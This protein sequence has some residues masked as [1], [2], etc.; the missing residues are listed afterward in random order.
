MEISQLAKAFDS[1]GKQRGAQNIMQ[2]KWTIQNNRRG[3]CFH[4][5]L[6]FIL[7]AA[8]FFTVRSTE[9]LVWNDSPQTAE[10][11]YGFQ[12]GIPGPPAAVTP[13]CRDEGAFGLRWGAPDLMET[14][15]KRAFTCVEFGGY[16][17]LSSV[18]SFTGVAI[19]SE[20]YSPTE[21]KPYLGKIWMAGVAVLFGLLA[22]LLFVIAREYVQTNLAA[23]SILLLF[24]FSPPVVSGAW[25]LFSGGIQ[26]TVP[27]FICLGLWLYRKTSAAGRH[28]RLWGLGLALALL[29]GPW[30]REYIGIV[31]ALIIFLELQKHRRVTWILV[32]ALLGFLHAL[33]P[34]ALLH[35]FLPKLPLVPVFRLGSLA[36]Q[37]NAAAGGG[38]SL[39]SSIAQAKWEVGKVFLVLLPPS[40]FLASALILLFSLKREARFPVVL[41]GLAAP[42]LASLGKPWFW[43]ALIVAFCGLT[44]FQALH[45]RSEPDRG[46]PPAGDATARLHRVVFLNVWF[47]VSLLPFLKVFSAH[48]H[49]AYPLI[50]AAILIVASTERSWRDILERSSSAIWK[51][52]I[53]VPV[54]LICFLDQVLNA[55][56]SYVTVS[57]LNGGIRL[58]AN[59]MRANTPRGTIVIANA[60]HAEDIRFY[61]QN[62]ILPYWSVGVGV[63]PER[64]LEKPAEL[65]KFLRS[66][67]GSE[68]I[69]ML[70]MDQA[71]S[72][73]KGN[74]HAHKYITRN[75]VK[76]APLGS[77]YSMAGW[78]PFVDPV[79]NFLPRQMV[80][81]LGPPD[82]END[83]YFGRDRSRRPF[84]NEISVTYKAYVVLNPNVSPMAYYMPDSTFLYPRLLE[85]YRD[86]KLIG[87]R[88]NLL[89]VPDDLP[90]KESRL[91][92][93]ADNRIIVG[94]SVDELKA[95]I[96][97]L[98]PQ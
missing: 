63:P 53:L 54:L 43:F 33:Y 47:L 57:A 19:F 68:R 1:S 80:L 90:L 69:L 15:F 96:D 94:T 56:G 30:V 9:G 91:I 7:A 10:N 16:R 13:I 77:I 71:F 5:V 29:A 39:W 45:R 89:A 49:L 36:A 79:R 76:V 83:I 85:H 14:V 26:V 86:Y 93:E 70:S 81:F 23:Y 75:T 95:R 66:H 12:N 78:F 38:V 65:E 17:P 51:K 34:T 58:M 40:L 74:F 62:H 22:V 92:P 20:A 97:R 4:L 64:T 46:L 24:F 59:W 25:I 50:P 44:L 32:L 21:P 3:Q 84:L 88:E 37:L 61:S 73:V 67:F 98:L 72:M 6:I 87:Y 31:A 11:L 42:V 28:R 52:V 41:A 18:I 2:E 27:L 60:L 82:L 8:C 35:L 55:Y 48:V